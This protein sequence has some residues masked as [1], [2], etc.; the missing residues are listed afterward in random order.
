[1]CETQLILTQARMD[2]GTK[3]VSRPGGGKRIREIFQRV[4]ETGSGAR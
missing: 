3:S 1:M 2:F 4:Q